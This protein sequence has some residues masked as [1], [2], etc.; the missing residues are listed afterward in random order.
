MSRTLWRWEAHLA[1]GHVRGGREPEAPK[2]EMGDLTFCGT[3]REKHVVTS[4]SGWGEVHG[5]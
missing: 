2:P 5:A 4:V 3:C 1:C